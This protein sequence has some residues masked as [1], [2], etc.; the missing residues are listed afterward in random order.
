M[1]ITS[2]MR[3]CYTQKEAQNALILLKSTK[4]GLQNTNEY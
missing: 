1:G 2:E 4:N 3:A